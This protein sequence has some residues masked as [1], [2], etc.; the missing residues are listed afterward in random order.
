MKRYFQTLL[1]FVM[2]MVFSF[3][4]SAQFC[5]TTATLISNLSFTNTFQSAPTQ[6]TG[7]PYWTFT[8]T[9]GCVYEFS[10]CSSSLDTRIRIYSGIDPLTA[11]LVAGNDDSGPF[12][13]STRASI[14][15]L[16]TVSGTYSILAT[17]ASCSALNNNL[18]LQYRAICPS[19]TTPPCPTYSTTPAS[20]I[21]LN[22]HWF[23]VTEL[24]I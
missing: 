20:P 17:R 15:W 24:L 14:S 21:I 19:S 9:A 16:C 7:R 12:C 23:L 4:G 6:S 18:I 11:T 22:C 5:N 1:I 8:A 2:S 10:T 13:S 3:Q